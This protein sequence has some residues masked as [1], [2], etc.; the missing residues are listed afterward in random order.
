MELNEILKELLKKLLIDNLEVRIDNPVSVI[1]VSL[2]LFGKVISTSYIFTDK[3][4]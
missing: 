3:G 1:E 4:N 2:I